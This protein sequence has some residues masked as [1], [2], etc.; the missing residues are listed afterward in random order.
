MR[1]SVFWKENRLSFLLQFGCERA[2]SLMQDV[3]AMFPA[4]VELIRRQSFLPVFPCSVRKLP[5]GA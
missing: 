1:K 5:P 3:L 4:L 2:N